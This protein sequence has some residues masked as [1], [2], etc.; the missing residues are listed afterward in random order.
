MPKEHTI[1]PENVRQI[2]DY[3]PDTGELKWK[4]K[5]SYKIRVGDN[6]GCLTKRGYLLTKYK[7]RRYFN[8]TIIWI[9][10]HKKY[11]NYVIDHIDGNKT[12]NK[13]ENLRDIT[14]RD[15]VS[16]Q[17]IHREGKLLGSRKTKYGFCS[18]IRSKEKIIYLGS[19]K[20][21]IEAHEAYMK[22]KNA[23]EQNSK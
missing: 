21:E 8:H 23:L 17:K 13:I 18:Y 10:S 15:N 6:V 14:V 22:A 2:F 9:F 20:T 12:N 1:T 11:P 3:N 5:I 7:Y 4:K 16:N 19:F